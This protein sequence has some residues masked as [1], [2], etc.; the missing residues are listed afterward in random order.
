VT[1]LLSSHAAPTDVRWLLLSSMTTPP[2]HSVFSITVHIKETSS[3]GEDVL[4]VGRLNLVYLAGSKN[5]GRSRAADKRAREAGLI[6]QNLLILAR[7]INALVDK[8]QHIR[9][10]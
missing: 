6:N 9:Y 1:R 7:V 4:K 3:M 5:I 8:S 10:Q 2:A